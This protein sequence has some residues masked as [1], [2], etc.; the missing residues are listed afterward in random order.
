PDGELM[1]AAAV[2]GGLGAGATWWVP[3]AG[4]ALRLVRRILAG[5]ADA[6][7]VLVKGARFTHM[8]RVSLGLRGRTIG[9]GLANCRLYINCAGC[10]QLAVGGA[11][12][13]EV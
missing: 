3:S 9:C 2:R 13:D 4:D 1:A 6:S 8:E 11:T 7:A 12:L 10:P 5:T